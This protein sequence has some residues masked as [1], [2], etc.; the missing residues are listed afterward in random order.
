MR[1]GGRGKRGG[2]YI[3]RTDRDSDGKKKRW[4]NRRLT[5][6]SATSLAW[7]LGMIPETFQMVCLTGIYQVYKKCGR[8][9]D[10]PVFTYLSAGLP[11]F[12]H[13]MTRRRS[14]CSY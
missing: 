1:E 6:R 7:S 9:S 12:V 14:R 3:G 5:E 13:R 11:Y 4:E 10:Q 2:E 8:M